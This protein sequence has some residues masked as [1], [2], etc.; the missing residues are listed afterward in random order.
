MMTCAERDLNTFN[1]KRSANGAEPV[2][3]SE[4]DLLGK[5]RT[6]AGALGF[7]VLPEEYHDT[8]RLFMKGWI[9]FYR[10]APEH[11]Y[12]ATDCGREVL[13]SIFG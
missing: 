4:I 13:R 7:G 11:Y 8:Y 10:T 12:Y 1:A 6:S 9:S 3:Q 5:I 2:P